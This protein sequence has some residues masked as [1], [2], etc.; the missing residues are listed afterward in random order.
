MR[1]SALRNF[2]TTALIVVCFG[3]TSSALAAKPKRGVYA[4][5]SENMFDTVVN[6]KPVTCARKSANKPFIPSRRLRGNKVQPLASYI[7]DLRSLLKEIDRKSKKG[8]RVAK[9]L[10]DAKA[11]KRDAG[12]V[13]AAGPV[14]LAFDGAG[15]GNGLDA[16]AV[17]LSVQS[18][19]AGAEVTCVLGAVPDTVVIES[20]QG[21]NVAVRPK[22][23]RVGTA[24]IEF[25][26]HAPASDL[27]SEP[28]Q[29]SISWTQNGEFIGDATS[30]GAYKDS[31]TQAEA[32]RLVRWA[33]MGANFD[34]LV[35]L[36]Q[37]P[38]G[39]DEVVD[40]LL[41]PND[42]AAC[43]EVE[44]D[45][46]AIV[47][48]LMSLPSQQI[49]VNGTNITFVKS[50]NIPEN[51][52]IW[53]NTALVEYWLYML[54][55]GCNP[56]RERIGLLWHN[57]F[58]VDLGSNALN[59]TAGRAHAMKSH[60]DWLRG[61][62]PERGNSNF[63]RI[64]RLT[65]VMHGEDLAM[66]NWLNNDANSYGI[67]GGN[68]NYPRELL[69]LFTQ[70]LEDTVTGAENYTEDDIYALR[71][72]LMGYNDEQQ[73]INTL[74]IDN[75][76]Y[77]CCDASCGAN[78]QACSNLPVQDRCRNDVQEFETE[79]QFF[80][81]R[82]NAQNQPAPTFLFH[83]KPWERFDVFKANV[84]GA[85]G[86]L[87]RSTHVV[88]G[89]LQPAG[90]HLAPNFDPEQDN[91]TPYLFYDVPPTARF[92]ASRLIATFASLEMTESLVAPVA[93]ALLDN[94]Y[95]PT[96]ALRLIL[97]S[98]AFF[99]AE[100]RNDSISNPLVR[101]ISFLRSY[102][103]PL[104]REGNANPL[105]HARNFSMNTGFPLSRMPTVFGV[106]EAGK[107]VGGA[108]KNGVT[109][110]STS[111]HLEYLRHLTEY[112]ND[113]DDADDQEFTNFTW[114][115]LMP[116]IDWENTPPEQ[117]PT[118]D[119]V[120]DHMT[121]KLG[122]E[123]SEGQRELL[124]EYLTTIV[125]STTVVEDLTVPHPD[126]DDFSIDWHDPTMTNEKFRQ[127]I[128]LKGPGMVTL[129]LSLPNAAT[130]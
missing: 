101:F 43:Q 2:L 67:L 77:G 53:S 96:E 5:S 127:Y 24:V 93:Q 41:T 64:D 16:V 94:S 36:A 68:E 87:G 108:I 91:L 119:E 9:Q 71:F 66:L 48:S 112:L 46:I 42:S 31:L 80:L 69:E 84:L 22:S 109:L 49:N 50:P 92:F 55:Y 103:L 124:L 60:V 123:L 125:T 10:A 30:L 17:T 72:A 97:S 12:P 23:H 78:C 120:L 33:G 52:T 37:Q 54:R 47:R 26:A 39:L 3:V 116:D 28:A 113:V 73:N 13:C 111:L 6:S 20:Q 63:I 79:A 32:I 8:K 74:V 90:R 7:R 1:G 105:G 14:P 19:V 86:D 27:Y 130:M 45:A 59:L 128:E 4:A 114:M 118:A 121:L 122:I 95:D 126:Y 75:Q 83:G 76:M 107:I 11:L 56:L 82:W 117:R 110:L 40:R 98:S 61:N 104:L 129:L 65:A 44:E 81:N 58:A 89:V 35:A 38:G 102:D 21:C 29:H 18:Q 62:R 100:N 25:R 51:R 99:A 34:E 115:D 88:N 70:G 85:S 106:Q 57:H 15:S